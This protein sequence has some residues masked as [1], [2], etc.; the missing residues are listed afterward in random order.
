MYIGA[1]I[2]ND[3]S[4][5]QWFFLVFLHFFP[6]YLPQK[7][8]DV[9]YGIAEVNDALDHFGLDKSTRMGLFKILSG[10][11]L[12]GNIG[13]DDIDGGCR[14][15]DDSKQVLTTVASLFGI[16]TNELEECVTTRQIR[17]LRY[18]K[19]FSFFNKIKQNIF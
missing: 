7:K 5:V 4:N 11:L 17:S 13:F 18:V 1:D 12:I 6:K 8:F 3:Y 10:I 16:E 2:F 19:S 9:P 14:V 15:S